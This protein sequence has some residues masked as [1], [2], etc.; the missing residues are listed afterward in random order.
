MNP[1]LK[2]SL[3]GGAFASAFAAVALWAAPPMSTRHFETFRAPI[4]KQI[5]SL[6]IRVAV[7]DSSCLFNELQDTHGT[8]LG[9]F[10]PSGSSNDW[11]YA[12]VKELL[13]YVRTV[14][15]D[16]RVI[17]AVTGSQHA[18]YYVDYHGVKHLECDDKPL[19][20][21]SLLAVEGPEPELLNTAS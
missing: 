13:G 19:P 15:T 5:A 11:H 2:F 3:I 21:N 16:G 6:G 17:A 1:N 20:A 10:Y 4:S 8:H 9:T 12:S 18:V 7:T 14:P